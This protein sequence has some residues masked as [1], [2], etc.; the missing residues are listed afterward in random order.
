MNGDGRPDLF[1]AGYADVN[2]ADPGLG[3][4]LPVQLSRPCATAST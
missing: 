1:V 4:R 2:I 3:G